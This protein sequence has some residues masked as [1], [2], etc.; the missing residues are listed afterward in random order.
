MCSETNN[1]EV[2]KGPRSR[3]HNNLDA[4][5]PRPPQQEETTAAV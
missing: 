5:T 2:E 4:P 1:A 3:Q